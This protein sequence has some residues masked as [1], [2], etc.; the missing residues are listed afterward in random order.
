MSD[1]LVP[2]CGIW[3]GASTPNGAGGYDMAAGLA[4]YE[5]VAQNA[6]DILH[7]YKTGNQRF[8]TASEVALAHRPGIQRSLLLYNWKPSATATWAQIANGAADDAIADV[9]NNLKAYPHKLFFNIYHEPEDNVVD[10]PGSGMTP[11]DYAA[12]YRHVVTELRAAGVTNAVFVWNTMGYH[13]WAHLLDGLYPGHDVVDWLCY[14]PYAKSDLVPD[15]SSLVDRAKSNIGWP[16]YYS[17]ATN[18]APGKPIMLCEW[19]VDLLTNTDP[20]SVLTDGAAQLEAEYPMLKAIVYWNSIDKV[21]ARIDDIS[22]KGVALGTAYRT[23]A[24]SPYF[25]AMTPDAAP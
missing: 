14:D 19:G 12:M 15:M 22:P 9:A 24:A 13:G 20:A 18:K 3:L 8:P 16:G 23:F 1:L 6:P 5:S 7:F 17:W 21:N 4:Q 25:N 10:S 11:A 2:S